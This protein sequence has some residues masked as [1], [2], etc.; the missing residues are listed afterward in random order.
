[1]RRLI[2]LIVFGGMV[3]SACSSLSGVDN[4][5]DL[6]RVVNEQ[7]E[8]I[9]DDPDQR[10][11]FEDE[12]EELGTEMIGDAVARGANLEALICSEAIS[13]AFYIE[14][15]FEA[16]SNGTIALKGECDG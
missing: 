9:G 10:K 6:L 3:L 1:M 11:A 4:C 7:I 16:C 5:S 8:V 12:V 13:D 15:V 2:G 14:E